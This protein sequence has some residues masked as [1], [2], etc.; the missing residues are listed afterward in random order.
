MSEKRFD[1]GGPPVWLLDVDGVLNA[2]RPGWSEDPRQG[3][4][5]ADDGAWQMR[6]SPT[7]IKQIRDIDSSCEVEIVWATTWCPWIDGLEEL[8]GLSG[9][10]CAFGRAELAAKP[11]NRVKL[12]A[13]LAVLA[14]S[15]ELIWTD[16]AAIPSSGVELDILVGAG[17]LLI[18]PDQDRGLQPTHLE[19]IRAWLRWPRTIG[20]ESMT[21]AA[22]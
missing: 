17:S 13:A 4:A 16:D 20:S 14:S 12:E 22:V 18:R 7:L 15:R 9:S 11:D 5:W 8:F 1:D 6:W 2:R 10:R 19:S 3:V 21:G